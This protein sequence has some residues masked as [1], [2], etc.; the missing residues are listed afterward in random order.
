MWKYSRSYPPTGT[1]S[2]TKTKHHYATH[3]PSD[4]MRKQEQFT[5]KITKH[6]REEWWKAGG[7]EFAL[8]VP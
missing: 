1:E 8:A 7:T 3:L 2:G 5:F 4:T 6:K